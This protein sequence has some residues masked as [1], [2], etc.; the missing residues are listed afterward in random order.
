MTLLSGTQRGRHVTLLR[1]AAVTCVL[2][3]S[4]VVIVNHVSL[5]N[6]AEQTEAR[7][8]NVQV[9]KLEER[10]ADHTRSSRTGSR[11]P[12]CRWRATKPNAGPSSSGSP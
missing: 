1:V 6:L 10:L 4:A 5:S 11:R 2:L 7:A 3:I 12:S 8:S 9:A